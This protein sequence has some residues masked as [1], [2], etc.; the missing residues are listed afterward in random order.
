MREYKFRGI[1]TDT[2]KWVYGFIAFTPEKDRAV[3]IHQQGINLMQHTD[4]IPESVGEYTGLPD[5]NNNPIYEGDIVRYTY[6]RYRKPITVITDVYW[7]YHGFYIRNNQTKLIDSR[8]LMVIKRE[9][10]VIGN[11]FQNKELLNP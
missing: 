2:G 6:L 9:G 10:E 4:V 11:I 1:S 5:K 7:Y 8:A 3:I